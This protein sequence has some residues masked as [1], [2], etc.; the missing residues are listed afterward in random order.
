MLDERS[1]RRPDVNEAECCPIVLADGQAWLFPKP[2]VDYTPRYENGKAVLAVES[3]FM[4]Y[5]DRLESAETVGEDL[6]ARFDLARAMLAKVYNLA[7]DQLPD[8]LR[9]RKDSE[10]DQARWIEI[11]QTAAGHGPKRQPGGVSSA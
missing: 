4:T 7:D 8:L 3:E 9:T 1:L 6:C 5:L 11:L 10:A 2:H